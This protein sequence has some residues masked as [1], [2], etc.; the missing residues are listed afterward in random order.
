MCAFN[1]SSVEGD[2]ET[3]FFTDRDRRLNK[4]G[5]NGGKI[6]AVEFVLRSEYFL[7]R[8]QVPMISMNILREFNSTFFFFLERLKFYFRISKSSGYFI[9]EMIKIFNFYINMVQKKKNNG[10]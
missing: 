4:A 1:A 5:G 6:R 10:V 7:F 8:M 9:R 2:N 3:I